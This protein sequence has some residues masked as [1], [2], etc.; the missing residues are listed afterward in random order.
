M[1]ADGLVA[2]SAVPRPDSYRD[3]AG[4]QFCMLVI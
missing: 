1:C 2:D 3:G 4:R